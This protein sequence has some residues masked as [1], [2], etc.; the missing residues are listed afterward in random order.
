MSPV[1]FEIWIF[2]RT[3][4]VSFSIEQE[5]STCDSQSD[6]CPK[7]ISQCSLCWTLP[8]KNS[9]QIEKKP[10]N[11]FFQIELFTVANKNNFLTSHGVQFTKQNATSTSQQNFCQRAVKGKLAFFFVVNLGKTNSLFG[12]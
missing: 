9:Q 2:E 3:L 10:P 4:L 1:I 7:G 12:T 8:S 5:E 11:A 6:M